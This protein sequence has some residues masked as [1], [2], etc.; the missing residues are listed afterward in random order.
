MKQ[1]VRINKYETILNESTKTLKKFNKTLKEYSDI[2]KKI[3]DLSDYYGSDNWY[4]DVDDYGMN[5]LP[6]ELKAG[7]LSEDAIY[8]LLIDNHEIAIELLEVAASILKDN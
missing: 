8:D 7:I 3:K 4:Q 5:L 2:Q 1:I 6:K